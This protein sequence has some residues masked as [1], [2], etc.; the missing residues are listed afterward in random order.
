MTSEQGPS[1]A[2]V[3]IRAPARRAWILFLV[4]GGSYLAI[5]A[6]SLMGGWPWSLFILLAL[7]L[8]C[9]LTAF[10]LALRT[11]GVDLT[12]DFAIV[13]GFRRR[14]K[15][16]WLKVQAVVSHLNSNGT[17]AVW[18]ILENGESVT[19]RYPTSAWRTGDALYERDFRLINQWWLAHRGESWRPVHPEAPRPPAQG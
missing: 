12:P 5:A 17:S 9:C 18:L 4:I 1:E 2:V 10:A 19:L 15:V 8:G 7:P 14:D 3:K 11:L 6:L 13:R 16:P